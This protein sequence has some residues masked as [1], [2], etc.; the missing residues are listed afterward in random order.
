MPAEWEPHKATWLSWPHDIETFP[1]KILAGAED[2]YVQM[3]AALAPH[4]EVHVLVKNVEMEQRV[5]NM[6]DQRAVLH[7]IPTGDTWIR[8][9]GP[10]FIKKENGERA[11]VNWE[12]NVWGQKYD[13]GPD[14][15]DNAIPTK[16]AELLQLPVFR[17]AVVL[18]GGSIDVNGNGMLLTT[19][20]CLLNPNR[21]PHLKRAEIEQYLA[22]Y[23]GVTKIIWLGEGIFGDDTDGHVDDVARFVDE[24][25]VVC[26]VEDDVSDE[27]YRALKANFELLEKTKLNVIA[28]PMPEKI[29]R[30]N[31]D[32]TSSAIAPCNRAPASYVNF[33]IANGIVLL[34]VFG[35]KNDEKAARILQRCF[36][37]R[38]VISIDCRDL[39]AGFG[40]IHCVTQ[41][42]VA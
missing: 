40:G 4:E 6:V 26:A 14:F 42:E 15:D 41:Q 10:I 31:L 39:V 35:H 28:M 16:I 13:Y 21:N 18:E 32:E 37:D 33:Y 9:F 12:F 24:K 23:L 25:T 2:T 22:G 1:G 34:P 29:I 3:I 19:E 17:P 5:R 27:N 11:I 7:R 8:D 20:Q 38:K 30:Q 36:P